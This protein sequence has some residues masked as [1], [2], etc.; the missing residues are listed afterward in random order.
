M[1]GAQII[2]DAGYNPNAM[3][4]FFEKL[5]AQQGSGGGPSFLASHPDPGNRAQNV[6]SILS[7]FPAKTY[8]AADS[9]EFVAAKNALAHVST[10]QQTQAAAA[11]A[12]APRVV[13]TRGGR[14]SA[15]RSSA[16]ARSASSARTRS[17][18]STTRT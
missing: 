8:A 9:A 18:T 10:Q 3:V 5:K 11:D 6:A 17:T 4:T 14:V 13:V 12:A 15:G 7:R 2:Y 1:V 16:V